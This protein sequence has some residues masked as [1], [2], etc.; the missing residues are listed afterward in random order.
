V[1]PPGFAKRFDTRFFMAP[2]EALLTLEPQADC[3]ELDEIAWMEIDE[4][5]GLGLISVTQF[6]VQ[7]VAERLTNPDRPA[8]HLRMLKRRMTAAAI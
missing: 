1:T 6:I 2:A 4:A 7:E 3:G 5:L 8:V